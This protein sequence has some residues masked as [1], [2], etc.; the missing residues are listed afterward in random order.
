MAVEAMFVIFRAGRQWTAAAQVE[1]AASE[2]QSMPCGGGMG[3]RAKV[4]RP[5]VLAE[6]GQSLHEVAQER[7]KAMW[8]G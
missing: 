4:T 3:E 1:F 2:R 8:E 6:T 7:G 5:V